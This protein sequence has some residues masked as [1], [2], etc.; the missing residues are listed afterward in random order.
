MTLPGSVGVGARAAARLGLKDAAK[1]K[2]T[3]G[4]AC[5]AGTEGGEA[6][7]GQ[8][9]TKKGEGG[10]LVGTG[11]SPAYPVISGLIRVRAGL[12][13]PARLSGR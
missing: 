9:D 5:T 2:Q 6:G 8:A 3:R 4:P 1:C 10:E 7:R 11:A 12:L 13:S